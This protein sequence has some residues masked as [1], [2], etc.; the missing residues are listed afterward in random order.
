MSTIN[1]IMAELQAGEAA[2]ARVPELEAAL[3]QHQ[4]M[5]GVSQSHNQALE[6]RAKEREDFISHQRSEIEKLKEERDDASFR[7]LEAQ[8]RLTTLLDT[9]RP[10]FS[11][12]GRAIDHANPPKP[13]PKPPEVKV[14]PSRPIETL[15]GSSTSGDKSVPQ[16]ITGETGSLSGQAGDQPSHTV[17]PMGEQPTGQSA[18]NP[19]AQSGASG[20]ATQSTGAAPNA[21]GPAG[22]LASSDQ[23]LNP[24]HAPWEPVKEMPPVKHEEDSGYRPFKELPF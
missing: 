6:L 2:K 10:V 9:V 18:P 17:K 13:E 14:E 21:D 11:S 4:D 23:P 5:L 19:T 3:K 8:D 7:E 16:P 15:Q 22:A 12:L 24:A 20:T 1:A